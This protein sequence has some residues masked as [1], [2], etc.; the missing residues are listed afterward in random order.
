MALLTAFVLDIHNE[1]A[2]LGVHLQQKDLLFSEIQPVVD[3]TLGH[4][5]ASKTCDGE[6]LAEMR[7]NIEISED[8]A[9]FKGEDLKNYGNILTYN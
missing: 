4:L 3:S 5:E 1:F 9:S 2:S 8:N 6:R 7:Q